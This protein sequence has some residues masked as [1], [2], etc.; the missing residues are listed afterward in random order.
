[1]LFTFIASDIRVRHSSWHRECQCTWSR[2]SWVIVRSVRRCGTHIRHQK[3]CVTQRR[4]WTCCFQRSKMTRRRKKRKNK[5]FGCKLGCSE[6]K[7]RRILGGFW[8]SNVARTAGLEPTTY[9]LEGLPHNL[10][11]LASD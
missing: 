6:I 10:S 9:G 2:T 3:R 7:T 1:M 8:L 5:E 11:L 4:K